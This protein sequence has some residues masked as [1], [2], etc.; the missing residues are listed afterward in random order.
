M[1]I[2]EN[3]TTVIDAPEGVS[4]EAYARVLHELTE[5]GTVWL[6]LD[7]DLLRVTR[8]SV[9][10]DHPPRVRVTGFLPVAHDG[11]DVLPIFG[12]NPARR[13]P[14]ARPAPAVR[15]FSCP[16]CNSPASASP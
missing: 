6:D 3:H 15:Q 9:E 13:S 11:D 7:G 8:A 1:R 2:A 5:V 4:A 14:R 16:E 10:L 12:M